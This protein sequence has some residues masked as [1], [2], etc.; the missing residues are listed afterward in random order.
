[1]LNQHFGGND[2]FTEDNNLASV[3]YEMHPDAEH[4]HKINM[5]DAVQSAIRMGKPWVIRTHPDYAGLQFLNTVF[6]GYFG[7]R[8]M[9]NIREDKGYTYG[10]GSTYSSYLKTGVFRIVSEVGADVADNAVE[11]IKTEINKL[12][13]ETIKKKELIWYEIMYW[14]VSSG[15]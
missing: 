5:P 3:E 6:G 12:Q 10:I 11:E 2:W 14:E 13:Q 8:L 15:V 9:A 7:S 1:M 4:Y